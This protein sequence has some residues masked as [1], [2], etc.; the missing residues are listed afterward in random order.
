MKST[1][2][3]GRLFIVLLTMVFLAGMLQTAF[4]QGQGMRMS[5]KQRA[6]TLGKQLGL[7]SATVAKVA[8][9]YE[10]YQKVM[11]DKRAELQGD[12]EAM[13][14]AMT[15]I[16]DTQNKEIVALLTKEQAKK[17]EEIQKQQQQRMMNRPPRTN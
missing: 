16:R 2:G 10:K 5:P 9:I 17:Y 15:E 7:D 4:A 12:M 3:I 14:A 1:T 6:D 11:A 13:R 8:A